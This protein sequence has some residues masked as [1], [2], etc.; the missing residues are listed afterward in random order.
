[1]STVILHVL[2]KTGGGLVP[3]PGKA[4]QPQDQ[5]KLEQTCKYDNNTSLIVCAK[6]HYET[7]LSS[8]NS[9]NNNKYAYGSSCSQ[10][11]SFPHIYILA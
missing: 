6:V 5:H 2:L 8:S 3:W 7:C 10:V 9:T 11:L 4:I 1:M